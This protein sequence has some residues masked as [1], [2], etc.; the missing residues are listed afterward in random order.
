V[1]P[2]RSSAPGTPHEPHPVPVAYLFSEEGLTAP[3]LIDLNTG[4]IL[5]PPA[6][7]VASPF[8]Q[9]RA[10]PNTDHEFHGFVGPLSNPVQ[11][12]DPRS[13]TEAR[14]LFMNNFNKHTEL[15]VAYEFQVS[16]Q[17][18]LLN[19]MVVAELI[20]RYGPTGLSGPEAER[21]AK[22][23]VRTAGPLSLAFPRWVGS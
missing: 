8:A 16:E 23:A 7:P 4:A 20:F 5:T 17:T 14:Y 21:N 11:F 19:N 12:K 6:T 1:T 18:Q 2:I 10:F 15:G 3:T 22:P 13:L 9:P